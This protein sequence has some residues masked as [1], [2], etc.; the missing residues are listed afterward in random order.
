VAI[1]VCLPLPFLQAGKK[2]IQPLRKFYPPAGGTNIAEIVDCFAILGI[3]RMRKDAEQ[4]SS[5]VLPFSL[6]R[7][8]E[9]E[10]HL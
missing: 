4:N 9:P 2:R 1:I 6:K 8:E 5:R 7:R 10:V 3:T